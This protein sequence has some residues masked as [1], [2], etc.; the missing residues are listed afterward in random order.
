VLADTERPK[1]FY[2]GTQIAIHTLSEPFLDPKF[3]Q[4]H[5]EGDPQAPRVFVTPNR[6]LAAIFSLKVPE[7]VEI[8][9]GRVGGLIV[10]SSLP[11]DLH[12]GWLFTC[13]ENPEL[14]FQQTILRGQDTQ[15][16]VS[17]EKVRVTKPVFIPLKYFARQCVQVYVWEKGMNGEMWSDMS[18]DTDSSQLDLTDFYHQY[19]MVGHLRRISIG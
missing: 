10:Y 14:P 2:H 18:R 19:V 7:A 13:P 6:L 17:C 4:N 16:W 11:N 15:E 9:A 5:A 1:A 12:G 8:N 3:D